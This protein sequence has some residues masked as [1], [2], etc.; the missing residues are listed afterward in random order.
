[1]TGKLFHDGISSRFHGT[2]FE[3]LR[4]D[5]FNANEWSNNFNGLPTPRQRWNEYG[6][7]LGGP[8]QKNK[9]FFFAD[10][11]GS[12]FDLPASP[13]VQTRFTA[14]NVSGNLSDF[15]ISVHYV[16]Q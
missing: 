9:L 1:M 15:G 10:F 7:M 2:L 16:C 3:Y 8:V 11:H 12:R 4:N 6:G 14:Q 5:F 13:H